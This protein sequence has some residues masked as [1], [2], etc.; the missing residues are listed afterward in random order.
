[1]KLHGSVT[2]NGRAYSS[3]DQI[4]G[5]VVYPF[6][7]I[8]M[9]AFGGAG[10]AMAYSGVPL[11]M[12]YM[13][14]G[15]AILVYLIFYLT[16]FGLDEVKWMFINAGL[17]IF[18]IASQ[19]DWLLSLFGKHV[20]DYPWYVHLVPFT[21]FILYTFLIRHAVLDVLGVRDDDTKR[22]RAEYGYV[23]VSLAVYAV[24]HLLER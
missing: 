2:L 20:S 7:M 6:F 11:E 21:Y 3:G 13:H 9:L 4:S 22:S 19:I 15:I 8:H 10:F 24:A 14:G 23:G 17:G 16:I 5:A 18:G 12:V 1:M